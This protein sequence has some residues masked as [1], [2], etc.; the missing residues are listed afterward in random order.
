MHQDTS[1]IF[2]DGPKGCCRYGRIGFLF[3]NH[4]FNTIGAA[5]PISTEHLKQKEQEFPR[6]RKAAFG[7]THTSIFP[8]VLT[9]VI[10]LLE[11]RCS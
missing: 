6:I 10:R 5:I 3:G 1:R 7:V 11:R 2:P 4:L 9:S 8:A